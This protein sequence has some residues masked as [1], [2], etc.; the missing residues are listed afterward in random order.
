MSQTNSFFGLNFP[1]P[2]IPFNPK[3]IFFQKFW[4]IQLFI[5][6]SPF[7]KESFCKI[8]VDISHTKNVIFTAFERAVLKFQTFIFFLKSFR[9]FNSFNS[10][11]ISFQIFGPRYLIDSNPYETV[12][13]PGI[14]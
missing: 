5:I 9:D 1:I 12:L 8:L 3:L 13:V 14:S 6:F 4:L 7:F 10:S 2:L 11:G